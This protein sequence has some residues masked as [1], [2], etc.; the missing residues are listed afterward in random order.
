MRYLKILS[1]FI[2]I[3]ISFTAFSQNTDTLS[4]IQR[5]KKNRA[6]KEKEGRLLLTPLVGPAYT[7]ELQFTLAGGFMMSYK[8]NRFDSLIQRSS[9][10]IM[11]GISSTGAFFV[12]SKLTSFWLQDKLRIY[13][14]FVYKDMPDNYWG[15]GYDK[16]LNTPKSDTTTAY[17]REWWQ[18]NPKFMWQFKKNNFLGLN[19][20]LNYTHGTEACK[21]V[22]EDEYY[23][24][25]NNKPF[26]SGL[27]LVYQFDS[28]DI[29]VNA[30][31]GWFAEINATIYN[32]KLSGDND[33]MLLSLDYR[34]YWQIKRE[35]S[36]LALQVKARLTTGDVPYGE[37]S[38][39]GTPFD[40]RGYTWGHY[41]HESMFFILPEYRY[42]FKKGKGLSK[43]GMVVWTGVGTLGEKVNEFKSW[44]PNAGIGYRYEVQPRMNV[45]F[46][47][48]IGKESVGFYFNFNEAF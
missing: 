5:V 20:D 21:G 43:H 35:G 16:A 3:N 17:R 10:P 29:P 32:T 40:L 25:F 18:I 19:V 9:S 46:D 26:N 12:N 4:W 41:R 8:T 1:A 30:W 44:L 33:Y 48:G 23:K 39:L 31:S 24:E 36:I 47:I 14:D 45:R 37:M 28:R 13:G 15:V 7:P 27:G 6:I 2:I 34:G 22:S 42:T 38:Q 11:I